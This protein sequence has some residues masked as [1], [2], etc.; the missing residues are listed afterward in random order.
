[1]ELK[2]A[3]QTNGSFPE[4]QNLQLAFRGQRLIIFGYLSILIELLV[5]QISPLPNPISTNII[6]VNISLTHVFH[7]CCRQNCF[8]CLVSTESLLCE[9]EILERTLSCKSQTIYKGNT[10]AVPGY[11]LFR[12]MPWYFARSE[13]YSHDINFYSSSRGP[14]HNPGFYLNGEPKLGFFFFSD[15]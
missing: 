14:F 1:M 3:I 6:F 11:I 4:S 5:M 8:R 7:Q 12:S 15:C 2:R 9:R 10:K 13:T